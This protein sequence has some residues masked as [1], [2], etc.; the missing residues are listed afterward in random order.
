MPLFTNTTPSNTFSTFIDNTNT[1]VDAMNTLLSAKA[2]LGMDESGDENYPNIQA[3]DLDVYRN[4]N[5]QGTTS[6]V[7]D[8]DISS[9]YVIDNLYF[10]DTTLSKDS[11]LN[12]KLF[13]SSQQDL[14]LNTRNLAVNAG[15]N[16]ANTITGS[17]T[18]T[19][20]ADIENTSSGD[21]NNIAGANSIKIDQTNSAINITT[22][23]VNISA[24]K[25]TTSIDN[26]DFTTTSI[27]V[28]IP[29]SLQLTV[30]GVLTNIRKLVSSDYHPLNNSLNGKLAYNLPTDA[31]LK[32][33]NLAVRVKDDNTLEFNPDITDGTNTWDGLG[34]G[35][36]GSSAVEYKNVTSGTIVPINEGGPVNIDYLLSSD[37][38]TPVAIIHDSVNG[39]MKYVGASANFNE[40]VTKVGILT[41]KS[42][43]GSTVNYDVVVTFL[44]NFTFDVNNAIKQAGDPAITLGNDYFVS[45]TEAG[46]VTTDENA[47]LSD[48]AFRIVGLEGNIATGL[49]MP[50]RPAASGKGNRLITETFVGD[51]VETRYDLSYRV[52][53]ISG[54]NGS[55]YLMAFIAG[56]LDTEITVAYDGVT[57]THYVEF[58]AP[59]PLNFEVVIRY[60]K[61]VP[62]AVFDAKTDRTEYGIAV[63]ADTTIGAN[64]DV[65]KYEIFTKEDALISADVYFNGTDSNVITVSS[66]ISNTKDNAG[67][68]NLYVDGGIL[69]AQN[70][71]AAI[72]SLVVYQKL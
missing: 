53:N 4:V 30:D 67:T 3:Y 68:L 64:A 9:A 36:S 2:G 56:V 50:Y 21:I 40:P 26:I 33:G 20:T 65:G 27:S 32:F 28:E 62:I 42:Q 44:G 54:T 24:G 17:L 35:G 11:A 14:Q 8:L 39:V 48:F 51:G 15:G 29:T 19:V 47:A 66:D 70:K 23:D 37:V 71:T 13:A 49:V 43:I 18:N 16:I 1:I 60:F 22:S 12:P 41:E 72:V 38:G 7:G 6:F 63:D 46:K 34:G 57:Q 58:D 25:L 45:A 59:P 61:D 5:I 69:K 55:D 31:V 10:S 52:P